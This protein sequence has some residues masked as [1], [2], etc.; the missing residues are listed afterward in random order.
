MTYKPTDGI[1]E[2][3]G[4]AIDAMLWGKEPVGGREIAR[5]VL[6]TP[7]IQGMVEAFEKLARTATLL[8]Q[9]SEMCAMH[10]HGD[11]YYH[12][13]RP[14]WLID[15]E[16]DIREAAKTLSH[17]TKTEEVKADAD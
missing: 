16:R 17:F 4:D 13:G 15:A 1:V 12:I 3:W 11:D 10:H 6:A 8:H 7:E 2:A 14:G 5:A 9:N